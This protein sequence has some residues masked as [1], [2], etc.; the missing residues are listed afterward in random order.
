[1]ADFTPWGAKATDDVFGLLTAVPTLTCEVMSSS[2]TPARQTEESIQ[3]ND[4]GDGCAKITYGEDNYLFDASM[5]VKLTATFDIS[6]LWLG[7]YGSGCF[8]NSITVKTAPDGLPVITLTG[9]ITAHSPSIMQ[10]VPSGKA[11]KF[12]LPACSVAATMIA[13]AFG[14]HS[15]FG[16]TAPTGTVIKSSTLEFSGGALNQENDGEGNLI[17]LKWTCSFSGGLSVDYGASATI[18]GTAPVYIGAWQFN[19][20]NWDAP[21]ITA[22]Q[23]GATEWWSGS[24]NARYKVHVDRSNA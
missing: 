12:L 5:E 13:S 24:V 18:S 2:K 11:H 3:T 7:E 22:T 6:G 21:T 10:A 9:Q 16:F 14:T 19:T 17:A 4:Y 15:G 8:V 1:M 23:K 20:T